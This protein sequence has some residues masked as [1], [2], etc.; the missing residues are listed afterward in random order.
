MDRKR[1]F[2]DKK[3]TYMASE[4]PSVAKNMGFKCDST[5][6]DYYNDVC[7]GC[8]KEMKVVN[9]TVRQVGAFAT[10]IAL[11]GQYMYPYVL[12]KECAN[13]KDKTKVAYDLEKYIDQKLPYLGIVSKE[14]KS[15]EDN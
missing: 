12:C 6:L 5:Y 10:G 11:K 1:L 15:E 9:N 8:Q 3:T 4:V 2:Y 7:P 13:T 14:E